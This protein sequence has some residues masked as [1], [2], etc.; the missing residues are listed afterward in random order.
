MV[1]PGKTVE[2]RVVNFG[3]VAARGSL[4]NTLQTLG[5]KAATA[6]AT[7]VISRFLTAADYG[8]AAQAMA[9]ASF[10]VILQPL[11]L[12]DVLIA[13]PDEMERLTATTNRLARWIGIA[14][15]CLILAM[16]PAFLSVYREYPA[17]WLGSLL[18]VAALRPLMDAY[19]VVPL[20]SLRTNLQYRRIAWIDGMVQFGVTSL[21][22]IAA[23]VGLR[24]AA[25]V[26][27]LIV[28]TAVRGHLYRRSAPD[29]R[30][31]HY[32]PVVARRLMRAFLPAAAA[33]YT[34]NVN[35]MLEVLVLGYFGGDLQ[36]GFFAFAFT[37]A[38]QA[39]SIVAYQLGVVL[40]PIFGHLQ[41]DPVRQVSGFFRVQ[42]VLALI[43]VPLSLLQAILAEPLFRVAF[44]Q[45]YA[46]AI[47]VF[48]LIS[49]MQAFYF[50]SGP[51]MS[52]LRS[53]RRF[54]TLLWWQGTQCLLSVPLYALG[55]QR[56][57]AMG[58][59][60]A[61][62]CAWSLSTPLVVW[63]CARVAPGRHLASSLWV[64][65]KAW[66]VSAPVFAVGWIAVRAVAP[67]GSFGDWLSIFF[68]GPLTLTIVLL[69]GRSVDGEL[70]QLMDR[71]WAAGTRRLTASRD[72]ELEGR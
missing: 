50:A 25:I 48:Q 9:S 24:G 53:Q 66:L 35:T 69:L 45:E 16:I 29:Q 12:G 54:G 65:G 32:E 3:A 11:T 33:Q 31:G 15:T 27:P 17:V 64:F 38:A 61:S 20:S 55:A 4:V 36:T 5:N 34:H 39:N 7:L 49:L 18:A 28:G 13:H 68:I 56:G 2:R 63:L 51:S 19:L 67:W 57:G 40:Q 37:I 60:A 70:R 30:V 59:A 42:R 22:V 1:N 43:C 14:T 41:H 23:V 8:V 6:A 44:A 52:C 26:A 58:V 72:A 46:P 21:S 62:C 10:L 47:P 71:A